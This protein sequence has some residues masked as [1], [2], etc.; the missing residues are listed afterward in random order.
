MSSI[1]GLK[2]QNKILSQENGKLR[3]KIIYYAD[4]YEFLG[5]K[6]L[7]QEANKW[8]KKYN[9]LNKKVSGKGEGSNY[10]KKYHDAETELGYYKSKFFEYEY[11]YKEELRNNE[12]FKGDIQNLILSKE[13]MS[14]DLFEL[15]SEN[16]KLKENK[17]EIIGADSYGYNSMNACV[18]DMNSD[19]PEYP[20]TEEE[21]E[22]ILNDALKLAGGGSNSVP[23]DKQSPEYKALAQQIIKEAEDDFNEATNYEY[24]ED[25][26]EDKPIENKA[27]LYQYTGYTQILEENLNEN[28]DIINMNMEFLLKNKTF[29]KR[30]MGSI[31]KKHKELYKKHKV[32]VNLVNVDAEYDDRYCKDKIQYTYELVLKD[33]SKKKTKLNI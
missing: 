13:R 22:K 21:K 31:R 12:K 27:D 23:E 19:N 32:V 25:K 10:K 8:K 14:R 29:K 9:D 11:K 7:L 30:I 2:M 16:R 3:S 5:G 20:F 6:T 24:V 26:L 17:E 15:M 28:G 33:K 4:R 18:K 1:Q